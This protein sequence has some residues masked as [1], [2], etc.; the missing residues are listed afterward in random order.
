M[1]GK[2]FQKR[3]PMTLRPIEEL[4]EELDDYT[5]FTKYDLVDEAVE[6]REEITPHLL[7]IL[8]RI[9]ADP[10]GWMGEEHDIGCYALVLLTHFEEVR[11]HQ[12]IVDIFSL[13]EPLPYDMFGDFIGETL[14][15]ALIKTCGGSLDGIR[16]LILNRQASDYCR[17]TACTALGYA[18]AAGLVRREEAVAFLGALLSG[19]EADPGSSFW[20]GVVD[21]L[22][23]L[24]PVA[25]LE[26]IRM[27]FAA[28]LFDETFADM[29]YIEEKAARNRETVLAELRQEYERRTPQNI[30]EYISWWHEPGKQEAKRL[31]N[32]ASRERKQKSSSRKKNKMVKKSRRKNR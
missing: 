30:H 22:I 32:A 24:H 12:L 26:E 6:R 11:A 1:A 9:L 5:G 29:D 4:L 27:A 2:I 21:T 31:V 10:E 7:A 16:E 20:Q 18:V 8:E 3:N 25:V 13:P 23:D 15:A 14:P 19:E 28:G 17:W